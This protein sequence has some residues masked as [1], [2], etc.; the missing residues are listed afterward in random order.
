MLDRTTTPHVMELKMNNAIVVLDQLLA[1]QRSSLGYEISEADFFELFSAEQ[2]LKEYDVSF[3]E[4]QSGIMGATL[5]GGIDAAYM[6]INGDIVREDYDINSLPRKIHLQIFIIQAKR[7]QGFSEE[8]INKFEAS[9]TDLFDLTQEITSLNSVYNQDIIS[10]ISKFREVYGAST[11]KFPNIEFRFAYSSKGNEVHDNVR[12]KETR[13]R[14]AVNKLYPMAS[15]NLE[16]IGAN[17]LYTLASR[18]PKTTYELHIKSGTITTSGNSSVVCF[19]ELKDYYNFIK[20]DSGNKNLYIF[21]S[22]VRDYQGNTEVNNEI[23]N[24]LREDTENDFWWLNNGVTIVCS[25]VTQSGMK[26]DIEEPQI[27]NGL[28]TSTEIYN[29]FDEIG[30]TDD[31]LQR[32]LLVRVVKPTSEESRSKIIKSTNRQTRILISSFRTTDAIHRMIEDYLL[33][34]ELFYDRKKNHY[35]NLGKPKSK[36]ISVPFLAQCVMSI[37]LARPDDARARPSSLLKKDSDYESVFNQQHP[38]NAFYNCIKVVQYIEMKLKEKELNS[39]DKNNIKFHLSYYLTAKHLQVIDINSSALSNVRIEE[40]S[41]ELFNDCFSLV[42]ELYEQNNKSDTY[43]KS[44]AFVISLK[45]SL[46][47]SFRSQ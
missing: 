27:V 8:A 13:L 30:E 7:S 25:E 46:R 44:S 47:S 10:F 41:D 17:D 43:S 24:T 15:F 2:I 26:L 29:Y 37:L 16:F 40:I 42:L 12:R 21:E 14:A 28:Q 32:L 20:G 45:E 39:R 23:S 33:P 38:L 18:Q 22:N 5:D 35:K 31:Y 4:V 34:K 9:F 19:V 3:E 6:F 1:A 36:I 11:S